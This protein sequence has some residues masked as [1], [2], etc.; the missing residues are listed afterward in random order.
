MTVYEIVC[1]KLHWFY[2]YHSDCM[3][4]LLGYFFVPETYFSMHK[5]QLALNILTFHLLIS[6]SVL[7][8]EEFLAHLK[9][10]TFFQG[11]IITK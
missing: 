9:S 4:N 7:E 6:F 8:F 3:L 1:P 5:V 11:K 10:P 2:S